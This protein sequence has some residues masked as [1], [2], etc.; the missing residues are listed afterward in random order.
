MDYRVTGEAIYPSLGLAMERVSE[1]L[2]SNQQAFMHFHVELPDFGN[3]M[4]SLNVKDL[5]L[6]ITQCLKDSSN[7]FQQHFSQN[8]N[9]DSTMLCNTYT[10]L[11]RSLLTRLD[12]HK[13]QMN[14]KLADIMAYG[15]DDREK[16]A[17]LAIGAAIVSSFIK[18]ASFFIQRKREKIMREDIRRIRDRTGRIENR[19]GEFDENL[20]LLAQVT[21]ET[22]RRMGNNISTIKGDISELKALVR[23]INDDYIRLNTSLRWIR[24]F[25][26]N[27]RLLTRVN[28]KGI[29]TLNRVNTYIYESEKIL[30]KMLQGFQDLEMGKFPKGLISRTTLQNSIT[31]MREYLHRKFPEQR[32]LISNPKDIYLQNDISYNIK[33]GLVIIQIPLFLK[34]SHT[35]TMIL[36]RVHTTYVPFNTQD[37][38]QH[39]DIGTYT[40]L[41]LSHS[42][43]AVSSEHFIALNTPDLDTCIK[44]PNLYI[45]VQKLL[46]THMSNKN[47]FAAIYWEKDMSHID[48]DCDFEYYYN[49]KPHPE[50]LYAYDSIVL[51]NMEGPFSLLCT[52]KGYP[53]KITGDSY[54]VVTKNLFCK[55]TLQS[56]LYKI[57]SDNMNCGDST[58]IPNFTFPVNAIVAHKLKPFMNLEDPDNFHFSPKTV[59]ESDFPLDIDDIELL[60]IPTQSEHTDILED[61]SKIPPQDLDHVISVLTNNKQKYLNEI[62]KAESDK[63]KTGWFTENSALAASILFGGICGFLALIFIIL[64]GCHVSRLKLLIATMFGNIPLAEAQLLI[65]EDCGNILENFLV[66]TAFHIIY[67]ILAITLIWIG[68]YLYR[69]VILYR[70]IIPVKNETHYSKGYSHIFLELFSSTHKVILYIGTVRI[71]SVNFRI[72]KD[73]YLK[74]ITVTSSM[75]LNT[76]LFEWSDNHFVLPSPVSTPETMADETI[77]LFRLPNQLSLGPVESWTLHK[78]TQG[79]YS[80]RVLL[81]E[82]VYYAVS[83]IHCCDV[84]IV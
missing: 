6:T 17:L 45:C 75:F 38:K 25:T 49:I 72:S 4:N 27:N 23:I 62:R 63:Q 32:L 71:G 50:I 13:T 24:T 53:E 66:N 22:F 19:M 18:G 34:E 39:K 33:N 46:H 80:S 9:N 31:Q 79:D 5:D 15:R 30:D 10:E 36:Y 47:C 2:N 52:E 29:D 14:E 20:V 60:H 26:I 21:E 84:S 70:W 12:K 78:V 76:A 68:R 82:D 55:C 48:R 1:I 67:G 73:T 44:Y 42:H 35:T 7:Y 83:D 61:P 43:Y 77:A 58:D 3:L 74:N 64:I 11:A 8:L 57:L 59:Y 16:R 28:A 40:K 51:A 65:D 81:L 56:E 69:R 54:M 37:S 41:K